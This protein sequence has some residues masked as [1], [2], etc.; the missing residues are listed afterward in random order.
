MC[1]TGVEN[2]IPSKLIPYIYWIAGC[3]QRVFTLWRWKSPSS[4]RSFKTLVVFAVLYID[5]CFLVLNIGGS[6]NYVPPPSGSYLAI[7]I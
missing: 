4:K 2:P 6:G 3:S 5:D 7:Y 1:L